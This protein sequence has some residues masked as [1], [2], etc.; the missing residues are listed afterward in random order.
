MEYQALYRRWRPRGFNS[1]VGQAHVVTTLSNAIVNDRIAHAYLFTGPRGT[2]KTSTAKI[3]AKA[4]NCENL[5]GAEPCDQCS[6]CQRINEGTFLDVLEIDG[7][8]NRGI[9]EIREL[10]EKIKFAPAEGKYKIYIIDEVHMLTMEAFNALL[11]TLEEPPK[12]V[13]FILATTE[14]HKLPLTILSRCQRFDF[15]RF[16]IEE[17]R[18]R[19]ETV[20]AAEKIQAEDAALKLIA[21]HAEGGMRDALS[22]L[23]QC[24]A[25]SEG[26]NIKE[27]DV[28]DLLGLI[29]REEIEKLAMAISENQTQQA[30][31]VLDEVCLDGKDLFQF[32]QSMVEYFRSRLLDL[33][34]SKQ[35][36]LFSTAQLI[37][38]I[39]LLASA[40]NEVKRSYQ[41]SLPLELALIKLT[42]GQI[43][44]ENL[45]ARIEKLEATVATGVSAKS[46]QP[47]STIEKKPQAVP[48]DKRTTK[49]NENAVEPEKQPI[50]TPVVA[51][52]V[53]DQE[54]NWEALLTAV[55]AKR[56]TVG[57]LLQEGA[58]ASYDGTRLLV[59][60][61]SNLGFHV[62]N[63]SKPENRQ[64]IEEIFLAQ[65]GR[66]VK[67]S[68]ALE[69]AKGKTDKQK[70]EQPQQPVDVLQQAL[71]LFG[72]KINQ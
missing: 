33:L 42:T 66:P 36:G 23:E 43:S 50:A 10:R 17:I 27:A 20:L 48:V 57:A 45:A 12:F 26:A 2:G 32:G 3:L 4:L 35:P 19:L 38:I 34:T 15:K 58:V 59:E 9:D 14:A 22:L 6:A 41:N 63:L 39:Q 56:M 29:G 54:F 13:V 64:L 18:S 11:K 70:E 60:F 5:K 8:S 72:G 24:L 53:S 52:L 1:F 71:S 7:A 68:C 49:V 21:Q 28:R 62:D 61:P 47:V 37:E 40:T 16:T 31:Q 69:Q 65:F 30:L 25:H 51:G 44:Q 55:K 67:L 46:V